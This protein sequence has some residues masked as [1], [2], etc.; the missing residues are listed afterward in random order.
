MT[1]FSALRGLPGP[2][3]WLAPSAALLGSAALVLG[4]WPAEAV[5]TPPVPPADQAAYCQA[6][7]QA[8]PATVQG[9]Q[10]H[11]PSPASPYTAAWDSSPRTVLRC[12]VPRPAYLDQNADQDAPEVNDVQWG[13]GS[14]GHGGYRF[15]TALRKVYVEVEIPKGAYPNYADALPSLADAIKATDPPW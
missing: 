4:N 1:R 12:G 13:M 14:D 8:L 10:R 15:V 2:V 6:L 5:V 3:R 7:K 11:D 9:H